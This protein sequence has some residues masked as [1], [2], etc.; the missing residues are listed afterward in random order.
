MSLSKYYDFSQ[1]E[2]SHYDKG[3]DASYGAIIVT[4]AYDEVLIIAGG[5]VKRGDRFWGFP[6]GH[7][8]DGETNAQAAIREVKEETSAEIEEADFLLN[9]KGDKPKTFTLEFPW[10]SGS[11]ISKFHIYKT[12]K[13]QK[14]H[15]GEKHRPYINKSGKIKRRIELYL[16]PVPKDKF[17]PTPQPEDGVQIAEWLTWEEAHKHM[18]ESKSNHLEMLHDA[19]DY[20]KS[21]KR[22]AKD[23]KL[24]SISA[25]HKKAINRRLDDQRK[26][27]KKPLKKWPAD[28]QPNGWEAALAALEKGEILDDPAQYANDENKK[29]GEKVKLDNGDE[30]IIEDDA[31]EGESLTVGGGSLD[32]MHFL[33][34]WAFVLLGLIIIIFAVHHSWTASWAS[35]G[36]DCLYSKVG[37]DE[38]AVSI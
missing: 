34:L 10:E 25:D 18:A 19:F 24:P 15:P 38:I 21:I 3:I 27:M 37:E 36:P 33:W 16:V 28:M 32:D 5:D 35:G 22:I 14:E 4:K 6:K 11:D 30:I 23:K 20:L 29:S 26:L 8:E 13:K 12:K 2:S 31:E 7:R 17:T 1:H 9:E